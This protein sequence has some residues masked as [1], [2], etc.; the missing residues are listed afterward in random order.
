SLEMVI[1][2]LGILKAGGAYVPIDPVYPA[3]R[4]EYMLSDSGVS[5]LLTQQSLLSQLPLSSEQFV[6]CLDDDAVYGDQLSCNLSLPSLTPSHLAYVI[7]TSGSTGKPKGVLIP[8]HNV[9]RLVRTCESYFHFGDSDI[10]TLFH[11][12]AF[13]FSVWELWGALG[14][15]GILVVVPHWIARSSI[16]FYRLIVQERVTVLNQTPG[17]FRHLM[18]IDKNE[19]S[20]LALRY[21]VFGGE[22]LEQDSLQPW[23]TKYGDE[24]PQLINMYG[25]TETTVHA[26]YRRILQKDIEAGLCSRSIGRPLKGLIA[27]VLT[28]SQ[29]LAPIG[30]A[31]EL[32]IGGAGLARGYLNRPEL[33]AERFITNPFHDPNNP[34]S[35]E[36]LYRTGDL[37]R[38]MPDGNLEFLGR[39]DHQVKIRGY[40]IELGEVETQLQRLDAVKEAVVV[41]HTVEATGDKR[42]VGYITPAVPPAEG[43]ELDL[44][45]IRREL[46]AT[47]PEYM[48][49]SALIVL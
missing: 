37:A 34:S 49:P 13:D 47:L 35:S 25:I 32:Y 40:R 46:K 5:W 17:A 33:T 21:V 23:A 44:F 30:V 39:N 19:K 18:E 43:E 2:L 7:Y 42:L 11:S 8:H 29:N 14:H 45:P 3:E 38:W 36:R 41:A 9:A 31:G 28:E 1:G 4:I 10:W 20:K 26:S 27:S 22:S 15:G 24:S 12:Y 48:V 16:D 6:L